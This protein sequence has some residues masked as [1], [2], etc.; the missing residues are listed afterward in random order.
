MIVRIS[1]KNAKNFNTF[2]LLELFLKSVTI[3]LRQG[4]KKN[5]F[6]KTNYIPCI[7]N[8]SQ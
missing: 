2:I 3:L 7:M 4:Y 6:V 5:Q 1:R 8:I